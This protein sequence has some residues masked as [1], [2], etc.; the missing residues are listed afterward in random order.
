MARLRDIPVV[1]RTVGLRRFCAR[2]G[3]EIIDDNLFLFAGSLAYAWLLAIFPFVVFVLTLVPFL[4]GTAEAT[5][6]EDTNILLHA[7][8]PDILADAIWQNA[9]AQI[10]DT[11][12]HGGVLLASLA[13]ALW[14]ASGG[15]TVTMA[16]LDKCY[17]QNRVRAWLKRRP[18]ALALTGALAGVVMSMIV[19]LPLGAAFRNWMLA[20]GR[21]EV[22]L[23][24]VWGFD[25]LRGLLAFL[26]AFLGLG[27]LYHFGPCVKRRFTPVTPGAV[28]CMS[29]WVL[30]G[31]AFKL[32]VDLY[33]GS[34]YEQNY[35]AAGWVAILLIIFYLDA[36]ALLVGAEINS[37][38][39]FAVLKVPRGSRNFLTAEP[40][41]PLPARAG[42]VVA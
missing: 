38:M 29:M 34:R 16:A 27:L 36:V 11:T 39:D 12:R 24:A 26:V 42:E 19:L 9:Q 22:S 35:G 10:Q 8:L 40:P 20:D 15:V 28:F 23:W 30:L 18:M 14:I 7:L 13:A 41:P 2:V 33:S 37:E 4:P 31:L 6:A 25:L 21:D 1:L 3:F 32:Y 5:V 17:E